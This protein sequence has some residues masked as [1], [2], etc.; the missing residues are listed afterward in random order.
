MSEEDLREDLS[1]IV[2]RNDTFA[3]GGSFVQHRQIDLEFSFGECYG[4]PQS[5]PL[6]SLICGRCEFPLSD[7]EFLI[8]QRGDTVHS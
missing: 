8:Y 6:F 2:Y 7:Q 1:C 4:I 3:C 5:A